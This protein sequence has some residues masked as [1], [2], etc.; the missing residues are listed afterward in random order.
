[1][2]TRRTAE[3]AY[4]DLTDI[5]TWRNQIPDPFATLIGL[6]STAYQVDPVRGCRSEDSLPFGL[7][8]A[9][10]EVDPYGPTGVRTNSGVEDMLQVLAKW[11][12]NADF[13]PGPVNSAPGP[14]IKLKLEMPY[15][16]EAWAD[17]DEWA[18]DLATLRSRV[19]QLTG[20]ASLT[21]T[22]CPKCRQGV[23]QSR[24]GE[25]GLS[26]KAICTN[27]DC[28][29]IVDYEDEEVANS[30]RAAMRSE[31]VSEDTWLT[32]RQVQVIWGRAIKNSVLRKWV[33]RGQVRKVDDRYN[34]ADLNRKKWER[35]PEREDA[36]RH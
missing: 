28:R 34:L 24:Y 26:D 31:D 25:Q 18:A 10:D 27:P 17:W 19:A 30:Y 3:D 32:W 2:S 36:S 1:M 16:W 13:H 8:A 7:D 20:R 21:R 35:Q 33:E 9:Y 4:Q 14:W 29:A 15:S 5:L 23:L 11:A 22:V 12:S 6:H